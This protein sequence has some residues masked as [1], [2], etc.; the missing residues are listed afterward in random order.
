ME[1]PWLGQ[2]SA[3]FVPVLDS[4]IDTSPPDDFVEQVFRRVFFDS[5]P[6]N[7]DRSL[8]RYISTVSY[9]KASLAATVG[10]VV[11]S[12]T[13]DTMGAARRAVPAPN[14]FDVVVA[15]L[16]SGGM[17]RGGWAWID[18]PPINGI[19]DFARVNLEEGLGTWAME[20]MHCLTEFMDLYNFRP[21][22]DRFDN[23]ACACGTHPSVYTK[24]SL[25]WLPATSIALKTGPG[26]DSY[27]LHAVGSPQP[28][29][30]GR[31]MAVRIPA[32][33]GASY[34]MVE[35]RNRSDQYERR[36]YASKGIESEGVIV[37]EVVDK[38]E[39]Y[40]RTATALKVGES[41]TSSGFDVRV[42]RQQPGGFQ[43]AV[44]IQLGAN[45]RFVPHVQFDPK[46]LAQQRVLAADLVPKFIE[47]HGGRGTFV[48]SQKPLGGR[49][50][51]VGDS[52]EMRLRRGQVP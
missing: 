45:E 50:L 52:V 17:N 21:H 24:T 8:Q 42:V 51:N 33:G 26:V 25:N 16:L 27:D 1:P 28:T 7:V 2:R 10:G 31:R 29:P 14:N 13:P 39:V 19:G 44:N 4:R 12:N 6:S 38:Y 49:I 40:L 5:G 20:I 43:I 9:G 30:P 23:M 36:S 37:Y 32:R 41:F 3:I 15:V 18:N 11:T 47:P 48:F 34:F 22:L 35:A 46:N